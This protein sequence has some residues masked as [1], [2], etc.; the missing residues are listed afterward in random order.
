MHMRFAIGA[1]PEEHRQAISKE[2]AKHGSFLHI[3]VQVSE[4]YRIS[5]LCQQWT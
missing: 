3:P 2:E 1:V 4:P 5:Q